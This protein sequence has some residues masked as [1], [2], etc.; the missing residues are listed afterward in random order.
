VGHFELLVIY[1]IVTSLLYRNF[2][3]L[4]SRIARHP[5]AR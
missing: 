1:L 2:N 4:Q 5:M 3:P